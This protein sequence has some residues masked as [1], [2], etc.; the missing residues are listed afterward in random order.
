MDKYS[1]TATRYILDK[2][3]SYAER[4]HKKLLI[5]LFDPYRV[6]SALRKNEPRYDQE[7][8]DYL[9]KEKMTSF[10]MNI[11]QLRD[12]ENY[13]LSYQ[14]YVKQYFV[15]HYNPRGNHFFAYSIKDVVVPWLDPKPITYQKVDPKTIDFK[16]YLRQQ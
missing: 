1:L 10:D 11:V 12:F 4:E 9:A 6:M 5:V 16:N 15:G 13:K 14:D 3:R 2:L 7:I 8:V